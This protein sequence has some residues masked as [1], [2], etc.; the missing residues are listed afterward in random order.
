[1]ETIEPGDEAL[2]KHEFIL[3]YIQQL[4]IGEKISVRSIAKALQVSEGTAYRA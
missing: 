1:M 3:Q 4:K 2:T